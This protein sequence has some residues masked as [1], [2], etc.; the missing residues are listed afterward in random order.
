MYGNFKL[1][2]GPWTMVD[3]KS[4]IKKLIPVHIGSGK[5]V[6]E[7]THRENQLPAK[8]GQFVYV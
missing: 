1:V 2:H 4:E 3:S 7:K 8:T 5:K 6:K